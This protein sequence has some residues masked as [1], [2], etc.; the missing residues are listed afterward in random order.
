[1]VQVAAFILERANR[2]DAKAQ[3]FANTM[4]YKEPAILP[5]GEPPDYRFSLRDLASLRLCGYELRF[6]GSQVFICVQ[7][8]TPDPSPEGRGQAPTLKRL[9]KEIVGAEVS[10]LK[11]KG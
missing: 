1:M 3:R 4:D 5:S 7:S 10:R 8:L 2:K 6:L 11:R 9:E